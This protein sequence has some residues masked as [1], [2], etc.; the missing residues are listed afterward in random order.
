[1]LILSVVLVPLSVEAQKTKTQRNRHV[2]TC[3]DEVPAG[4]HLRFE[5]ST[6]D[7]GD[8]PR[9][10]GNLTKEFVFI[11]DGTEPLVILRALTSCSCTKVSFSKR[12]IAPGERG[13]IKV[14]YEL[15]K[16]EPG[17]FSKVIQ[18]FSTS[19]EGRNILTVR[20]NSIDT[21]KL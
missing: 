21:K 16:K 13:V 9:K 4:A 17:T 6:F 15:H 8:V 14:V 18:I 7:F 19:V 12:P 5:E 2:T 10:G 3:A 20:G 11:N 1:M